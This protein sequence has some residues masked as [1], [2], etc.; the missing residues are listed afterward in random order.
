MIKADF[1]I[2]GSGLTGSTI[3]RILTDHDQDVVILDRRDHFAGNIY[4][5]RHES[6]AMIHK[7]GPHYF[8]CGS[9]KIWN[10]LN[11]FT[12]FYDWSAKIL[13]KVNDEHLNWPVNQDY[14]EKIAGKNWEV[15]KGEA[16]NFEEACLAK[17]PW[18][19]YELFIKGYTEKQWGVKATELDKELAVRITINKSNVNSLT[20]NHK[21]NALPRNGYTEM[22]KNM[23]DGIPLELE[24]DYLQHK[25][26]VIAKKMVIF[27]G[28]IDEFFG[29]KYG[30]LKYRGQ[31]RRIEHLENIDQ[32]Q[33]VIQVN[34]PSPEDPR[35]RTI[36]WKH[37]MH[38]SEKGK[39][40]GTLLT[41]ET[42]F[43]PETA[44]NFEYP[45]PDKI[46]KNLYEQYKADGEKLNNV[47]ICGRLG[48]YRYYDM[49]QAI[50]RAMKL[51]SEIIERF[52]I[53]SEQ[54]A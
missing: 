27:T 20:P 28:P 15:F 51:A 29:Y 7:Y 9:E 33:P 11:R 40:K 18:Q 26:K 42:P 8:R 25:E 48:E 10:F 24:F 4:D 50:G 14:I 37:L 53:P 16:S 30:K 39:V 32:Y 19:L 34:Y 35:I 22:V 45:F 46:N 2:V 31:N 41:H 13:S 49:D 5:Y 1:V 23:I 17:M 3:A 47:L 12:E 6:G 36:E 43:T 52:E 38:S 21:W 54:Y 44:A